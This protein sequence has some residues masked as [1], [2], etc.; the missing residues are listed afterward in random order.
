[1]VHA[2]FDLAVGFSVSSAI[3]ISETQLSLIGDDPRQDHP[4]KKS[5]LLTKLFHFVVKLTYLLR[6]FGPSTRSF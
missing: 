6:H 1:M 2:I 4:K 3:V 5:L